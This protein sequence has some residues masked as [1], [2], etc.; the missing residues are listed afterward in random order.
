MKREIRNNVK[1]KQ[2][3]IV[4]IMVILISSVGLIGV[5]NVITTKAAEREKLKIKNE[6]I[7][8]LNEQIKGIYD[9]ENKAIEEAINNMVKGSDNYGVYY[10]DLI[11]GQ[12]IAYNE[13]KY[14]TAASTIK[15]ALVMNVA[16]TIQRG[17]LKGTDT[18]LYTSEEYEGGTGILQDYV[19]ADKTEVEVSKLMELAITYSDNI[20]TQMLKKTCE[21][22]CSYV[23]K[24]TGEPRNDEINNLTA[25][26][27]GII[28][29]RLYDNP[30]NNPLYD[31]IIGY[32]K[33]TIFHDRLDKYLPYEVVAHKIGSYN[34]YTHDTGIVYSE[35]PYSLSVYTKSINTEPMA[36]LSKAIYDLKISTDEQVK[37]L[38]EA[39]KNEYGIDLEEVN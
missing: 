13:N 36:K 32:M 30:D 2:M 35:R 8:E 7:M 22:I 16:D 14:F 1:R 15:V 34:E 39:Y 19:V 28:L 3:F 20:A 29:K 6:K 31:T 38:K 11:S 4:T 18:V 5:S 24:I 25:K 10:E 37:S 23:L 9:N 27:Q 21:P 26:Q 17:E 12:A 33:N